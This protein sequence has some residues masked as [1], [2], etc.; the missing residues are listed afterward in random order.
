MYLSIN[1]NISL[2]TY[3]CFNIFFFNIENLSDSPSTEPTVKVTAVRVSQRQK[4]METLGTT[5]KPNKK[6]DT[7]KPK[8]ASSQKKDDPNPNTS[9]EKTTGKFSICMKTLFACVINYYK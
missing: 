7:G 3:N 8:P 6:G 5:D 2:I 4:K 9:L 1:L